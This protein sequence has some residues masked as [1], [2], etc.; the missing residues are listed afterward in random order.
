MSDHAGFHDLSQLRSWRLHCEVAKNI[1]ERPSI[2]VVA[3]ARVASWLRD[4]E[5]HP[6]AKKWEALLCGP[7]EELLRALCDKGEE[8]CTLRQA[9]PFA[10]ALDSRT[11]WRILKDPLLRPHE[12]R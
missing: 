8:M 5:A 1:A 6:Y 2:V 4:S 3:K 10:G 9:S 12:A 7:P 11:R